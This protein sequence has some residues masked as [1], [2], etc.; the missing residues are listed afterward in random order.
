MWKSVVALRR[1]APLIS[2]NQR[3]AVR[4]VAWGCDPLTGGAGGGDIS[5][6]PVSDRRRHRSTIYWNQPTFSSDCVHICWLWCCGTDTVSS[7]ASCLPGSD[8]L[9]LPSASLHN[10]SSDYFYACFVVWTGCYKFIDDVKIYLLFISL[11][12]ISI[13]RWHNNRKKDSWL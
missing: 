1:G 10:N 9:L 11:F 13:W 6:S 2:E 7:P 3:V 8:L 12:S 5:I 4:L